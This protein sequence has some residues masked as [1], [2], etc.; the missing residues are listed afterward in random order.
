MI[1]DT[2]FVLDLLKGRPNAIS[3]L[4]SLI[5]ENESYG[6]STPT[7]FEIWS[8]LVSLGKTEKERY[9]VLSLIKEQIIY[10]LDKESAEEAGKIDG[11]LVKQG[12]TIDPE[13]SMI[14]GIAITNNQ[15]VL[16][17]DKHFSRID[18]L[19]IVGY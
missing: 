9:K 7:I 17:R 19:K 10:V 16:T 18:P 12:L 11:E 6:I 4:Q 1:L 15:K 14:A 8:G 2:T 5:D 13:D 3:K